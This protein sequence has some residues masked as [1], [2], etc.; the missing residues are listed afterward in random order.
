MMGIA[1][2]DIVFLVIIAIFT[3]RCAIRGAVSEVLSMAA[4]IFG[5]LSAIFFYKKAAF[6]VRERFMPN[7]K[8]LPEIISFVLLFL[9]VF[10]IIKILES[11]LKGI[12]EGIRLK[13]PDHFLGVILGFAEGLVIVCLLLFIIH[14][15]PFVQPAYILDGSFFAELLLP[16]IIG[17]KENITDSVVM[18]GQNADR[19]CIDSLRYFNP[20]IFFFN[21]LL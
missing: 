5:L 11:I 6:I 20:S 3:L 13:G 14:I 21:L 4:L 9:I 19:A 8:V 17:D 10:G 16:F 12:V 15:Q 7:I 1:I 18:L 2:V